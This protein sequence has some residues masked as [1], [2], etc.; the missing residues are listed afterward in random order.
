MKCLI[1]LSAFVFALSL[2]T[3]PKLYGQN[4]LYGL[5]SQSWGVNIPIEN[6]FINVANGE[7]H[8]EIPLATHGQRGSLALKEALVY[9]SRIWQIVGSGSYSFQ[10][11]NVPNSQAGWRFIK[12]NETGSVQ[13]IPQVVDEDCYEGN[14]SG[15]N[16]AYYTY[17]FNWTDPS[18][19]VHPFPVQ[20]QQPISGF[21]SGSPVNYSIPNTPSVS[22]YATDGS[23]YQISVTNYSNVTIYDVSGNEVYPAVADKNGNVFS[24]DANANLIDTIGR[25]PILKTTAGNQ[26]YYDVLTIGGARKRYTVTT[27]SINVHTGFGQSGVSDYSGSLTAVSSIGL[28]DGSSYSFTYDSGTASGNYGE[29]QSITLPTGGTVSFSYGNYLDSYQNQNRWLE[30][31][32]G[33]NGRYALVPSVVTQCTGSTK[34]GCQEKMTVTDGNG[35]QVVYLLTLNNGAW[36]SQVDYYNGTSAH[37]MSLVTNYN[38]ATSCTFYACN[39]SQWITASSSTTTLSDTG[40]IAQTKYQYTYPWTGHPNVVQQWDYYTG[41][42]SSVPTKET[43]Y[44]GVYPYFSHVNELDA[45]GSLVAQST[46]S[47]D[48][49]GNPSSITSGI[50]TT[51][52]TS[53]TYDSYGMKLSDTDGNGHTVKYANMCSD[54]YPNTVTLPITA[55]GVSLETTTTYDCSSGLLTATQTANDFAVGKSTTYTYFSS[56]T[57]IGRLQTM[58]FPDGGSTSYAYPSPTETDQTAAQ[59]SS[60]TVLSKAILDAYGRPYQNVRAAP[61]GSITS[62]TG[63]DSTGRQASITTAH[64]QGTPSPTDGTKTTYYDVL[65]RPVRM[66]MPDGNA[67]TVAYSGATQISTDESGNQKKYTYDAFQRLTSVLEPNASGSLV[68]ETDY[69]YN[70]LDNLIQVDQWGG[71]KGASS[72][73]D[74]KR[75][76]A[77]DSLGR[78]IAE[79]IPESQS[80]SAPAG[81]TCN[82][83]LPGTLW[84]RCIVHDGNG[85][86]TSSTDNP[87]NTITYQYDALNRLTWQTLPGARYGYGYD[88][89]DEGRNLIGSATANS[90]GLLSHSSNEVNAAATYSYDLMGRVVKQSYCVPQNCS[91]SIV[92]AASY[93][94]T[95][96]QTSL[97]YPD[98]RVVTQSYDTAN[99]FV[100]LQYA[101]WGSTS[102][103]TSYY[104][105]SSFAP[106]GLITSSTMGNG[107]TLTSSFNNRVAV[108]SMAYVSAGSTIWSKQFQWDKTGRNL[109]LLTDGQT[110]N[111]RQFGYDTLNRV[112]SALDAHVVQ[113][114][115]TA[116]VNISGSEQSYTFNPC[117]PNVTPCPQTIPDSGSQSISVNGVNVGNFGWGPGVSTSTMSSSLASSINNNASSPVTA[118]ASGSSITLTSKVPGSNGNYSITYNTATWNTSYFSSPSFSASGP[119]SLSGGSNSTVPVSGGLNETYVYDPFGNLTQSGNFGF[120][121]PYNAL[122]QISTFSYDANGDQNTDVFSHTLAFDPNGMLSSVAGGQETYTYDAEGNRV[123]VKGTSTTDFIYFGGRS[124]ALLNGGSYTDLI[125]AGGGL[126]AEVAGTQTAAPTYRTTDNLWSLTTVNYAPYGQV[127]SGS[128]SD[129]FGF[130]ALKWDATTALWHTTARQYS[131]QQGRWMSPDPYEGSYNWEDPQSLNRY[132]YV[133]G[134]PNFATDPSGQIMLA[135]GGGASAGLCGAAAEVCAGILAG[136]GIAESI[137][138]LGKLFGWWGSSFHGSVQPRPSTG[139]WSEHYGRITPLGAPMGSLSALAGIDGLNQALGLPTMADVGCNPVCDMRP[140]QSDIDAFNKIAEFKQLLSDCYNDSHQTLLGKSVEFMSLLAY[141]PADKD[142]WKQIKE[143]STFGLIKAAIVKFGLPRLGLDA[144]ATGIEGA[145][146]GVSGVATATDVGVYGVCAAEALYKAMQFT[147]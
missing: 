31:Y 120:S 145:A 11:T 28:P 1:R 93:D 21:C 123:E 73:G 16:P 77:F 12:G 96:N 86:V 110:G 98:G 35:N 4:Y 82:G 47:Y 39:G 15:N 100:G 8:I 32:S 128:T 79:N 61:E 29:L 74:R 143:A 58:A 20:T 142:H 43:D 30:S 22:G 99:R 72:P 113:S 19:A 126:I 64:L 48:V 119:S 135:G 49:S 129:P 75:V 17:W 56:G 105:A 83:A 81:R 131:S 63:Y 34:T 125:Y 53:A 95:G 137:Y 76:F 114:Y 85:N 140:S 27:S 10:P 41:S 60:A 130:T 147:P 124:I 141:T 36:N 50:G 92:A 26:T 13:T 51:V 115:A 33:G 45:T 87:G 136:I 59:T 69:Q 40:Q 6:G 23:G 14:P 94:L 90:I 67:S 103:G 71:A 55:N 38:F 54:A 133:N 7:I 65:G 89:Y 37:V 9:D 52:T 107:V 18:G 62:E 132:A 42:P 104:S 57:N 118:S 117:P 134:R 109:L 70:V 25:T 146:L 68:Y 101:K 84:T 121:Q 106:P 97:T 108:A 66:L 88:G 91:Y 78:E 46:Y 138:D 112:N 116:T 139:P 24:A 3:L 122:N 111:S 127:F 144:L 5:G 80:A 102:I 44:V 2:S